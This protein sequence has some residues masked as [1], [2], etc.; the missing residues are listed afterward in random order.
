MLLLV[1]HALLLNGDVSETSGTLCPKTKQLFLRGLLLI[2][3]M[4]VDP[5]VLPLL[6]IEISLRSMSYSRM[7]LVRLG[8]SPYVKLISLLQAVL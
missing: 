3:L 6:V 4:H 5:S 1:K 7:E 8:G 2:C